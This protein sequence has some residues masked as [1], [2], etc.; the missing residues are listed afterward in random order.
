MEFN[1]NIGKSIKKKFYLQLTLVLVAVF[2]LFA[3]SIYAI[4]QLVISPVFKKAEKQDLDTKMYVLDNTIKA[5]KE[6]LQ[7]QLND[8]GH[9]DDTYNYVLGQNPTYPVDS[10]L[11]SIL[12]NLKMDYVAILDTN[13]DIIDIRAYNKKGEETNSDISAELKS[14][15]QKLAKEFKESNPDLTSTMTTFFPY[16]S[17]AML[18]TIGNIIKNDK[19]GPSAGYMLNGI[20][21]NDDK[22]KEILRKKY[23]KEVIVVSR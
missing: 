23:K 3:L 21:Y 6:K 2:I 7:Q 5:D 14:Q 8:W 11:E 18:A 13:G 19:T 16:K 20:I 12:S 1:L 10:G 9:W 15:I 22:I 4:S 17:E